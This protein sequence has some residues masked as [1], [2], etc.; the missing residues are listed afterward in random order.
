[1]T[2]TRT[3]RRNSAS[4]S[5]R[6]AHLQKC[7]TD[8]N[9]HENASTPILNLDALKVIGRLVRALL[10]PGSNLNPGLSNNPLKSIRLI[11]A[12]RLIATLAVKI[13]QTQKKG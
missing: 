1:M 5:I 12:Q 6:K 9:R 2:T 13:I 10:K 7:D 3:T 4:V 11:N 8:A